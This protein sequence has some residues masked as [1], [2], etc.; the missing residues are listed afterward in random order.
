MLGAAGVTEHGSSPQVQ[1]RLLRGPQERLTKN[2]LAIMLR[3]VRRNELPKAV[4]RF[5]RQKLVREERLR[6]CYIRAESEFGKNRMYCL[7]P[8]S[9]R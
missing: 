3:Q 1:V 6:V 4:R 8:S 9:Q 5:D 7:A 2:C